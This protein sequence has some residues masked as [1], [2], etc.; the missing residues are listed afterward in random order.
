MIAHGGKDGWYS[1]STT[2]ATNPTPS[3][4][5]IQFNH[6]SVGDIGFQTA[7]DIAAHGIAAENLFVPLSGGVDSEFVAT[8]LYRNRIPFTPVIVQL[9]GLTEH[10]Y[11][12]NWC[13]EHNISPMVL[14]LQ[15]DS[16]EVVHTVYKLLKMWPNLQSI[17][18]IVTAYVLQAIEDLGGVAVVG[19]P[20][21]TP[22]QYNNYTYDFDFPLGD[23]LDTDLTGHV[24]LFLS[25]SSIPFL[26][27]TPELVLATAK[28]L[29][30]NVN[31]DVARAK[32][33]QVPYRPKQQQLIRDFMSDN[34]LAKVTNI[35][36]L[37]K[38]SVVPKIEWTRNQLIELLTK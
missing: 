18:G 11:A 7:A 5:K 38:Y 37:P 15:K 19:D 1:V 10:Y 34:L 36:K 8:V 32:L 22:K 25:D 3:E 21:L 31:F 13:C 29:P 23:I 20:D 26:W 33:Y 24:A 17:Q 30:T 28:Q 2:I 6:T 4:F 16:A 35:F 12:L 14:Q 27:R 9:P